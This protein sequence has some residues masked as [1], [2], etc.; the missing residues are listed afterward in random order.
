LANTTETSPTYSQI[1]TFLHQNPTTAIVYWHIGDNALTTFLISPNASEI[2]LIIPTQTDNNAAQIN[3][4]QN[5]FI[6]VF[7]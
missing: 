6:A 5:W 4:L 7:K 2:K 3:E 1:C